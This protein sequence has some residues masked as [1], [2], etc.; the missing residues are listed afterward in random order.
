MALRTLCFAV[1]ALA[2]VLSTGCCRKRCCCTP[3]VSCCTACYSPVASTTP[4]TF[5]PIAANPYPR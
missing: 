2:T 1:V 3:C 5:T 4:A